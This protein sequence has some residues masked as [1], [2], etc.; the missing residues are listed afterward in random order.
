MYTTCEVCL[1]CYGGLSTYHSAYHTVVV[2]LGDGVEIEGVK[3]VGGVVELGR[4]GEV[5]MVVELGEV[6]GIVVLAGGDHER[7]SER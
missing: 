4:M 2:V 5:K 3:Q 7:A 1:N 6:G